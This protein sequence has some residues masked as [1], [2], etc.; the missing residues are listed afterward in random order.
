MKPPFMAIV[1]ALSVFA[2]AAKEAGSALRD[3]GE[4]YRFAKRENDAREHARRF[5][6]AIS[7]YLLR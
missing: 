3:F 1:K 4:S 7:P 6:S 5:R 2:D